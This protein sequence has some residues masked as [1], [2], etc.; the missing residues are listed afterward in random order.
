MDI[1]AF[2]DRTHEKISIKFLTVNKIMFIS[3]ST[4]KSSEERAVVFSRGCVNV[5]KFIARVLPYFARDIATIE[6]LYVCGNIIN[7]S[8]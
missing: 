3:E 6:S 2:E 7:T 4:R 5:L 1:V 8:L